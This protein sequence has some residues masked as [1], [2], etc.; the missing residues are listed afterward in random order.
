MK[1]IQNI[2]SYKKVYIDFYHQTPPF[3]LKMIVF[4]QMVFPVRFS[5]SKVYL[6]E[7]KFYGE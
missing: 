1:N 2:I 7:R 6:F 4:P 3:P 5:C